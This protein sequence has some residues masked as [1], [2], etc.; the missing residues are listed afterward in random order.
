MT[1]SRQIIADRFEIQDLERDLLGRGGMGD[2]YRGVDLQTG[3]AVAIKALRPEVVANDLNALAR[4]PYLYADDLRAAAAERFGVT[5]DQVA[6]GCGSDDIL[7]SLWRALA[8]T[9]G[10]V[11]YPAPTFSMV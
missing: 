8:E 4:Y 11:R 1:A 6:T 5:P 3:Q 2:V 9:D 7:D 10:V